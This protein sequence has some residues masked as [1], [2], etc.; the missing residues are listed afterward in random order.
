MKKS[1]IIGLTALAL[2]FTACDNIEDSFSKPQTNPQLPGVSAENVPVAQGSN[3]VDLAAINDA[4]GLVIV[5]EV[6]PGTDWPEGF[7]PSVPSVQIAKDDTFDGAVEIDAE[8]VEGNVTVSPDAWEAAHTELYGKNPATT[9]SYVRFPVYA[10]NGNQLYRMGGDDYYYG[11]YAV[12]VT[13]F[14]LFNGKVIEETYYLLTSADG[15]A[16]DKA[17]EIPR[18]NADADPYDAP[19]FSA[20]INIQ[21]AGT[22]WIIIPA[23]TYAAGSLSGNVAYGVEEVGDDALAGMLVKSDNGSAN[24]GTIVDANPYILTLDM[25]A[26]TYD[27]GTAYEQLYVPGGGNG[28]SFSTMLFTDNY[29]QYKGFAHLSGA[30]KLTADP[31]WDGVTYGAGAEEGTIKKGGGD[32]S[33]AEDNLYFMNVDLTTLSYELTAI[34]AIGL[35]GD[36][37]ANG[38]DG[39][40]PMEPSADLLMWTVTTELK[41]GT[42]KFRMNGDWAINLGGSLDNLE[43]NGDNIS[44]AS[45]GEYVVVLD[46]SAYPYSAQVVPADEW[47]EPVNEYYLYVPGGANGW[48]QTASNPLVSSDGVS[49]EGYTYLKDEFKF[50]TGTDWSGTNY[51]LQGGAVS[52]AGDAGNFKVEDEGLYY[53][54]FNTESY[55][56][57]LTHYA[58]VGIIGNGG[59]WD[60]DL[61]MTTE[62]YVV[63]TY[64]GALKAGDFKFRFD[65]KWDKNYG[66]DVKNLSEGGDN[67]KLGE[68]G[69]YLVTLDLSKKPYTCTIEKK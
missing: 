57:S 53:A 41:A 68:D 28:W 42:F 39:D 21:G 11:N 6:A 23:S 48:S 9:T 29:I 14:D 24:V 30:F 63:W 16:F 13:P 4:G 18:E 52:T 49:F 2:G 27:F 17:I 12:A 60:N 56:Y 46:L 10:A 36:A 3:A 65:A 55:E 35:I 54:T 8:L 66:G 37:T 50:S 43:L 33:V 7:T 69:N 45:D 26:L 34:D 59:D 19:V 32:I 31:N 67:I 61:F 40:T 64:E 25:E 22:E 44:V 15:F 1:L 51:G 58:K 20:L 5:A 62:N 47:V 38:W